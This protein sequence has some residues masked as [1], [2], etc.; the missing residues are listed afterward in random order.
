MS[1]FTPAQL[2]TLAAA[3]TDTAPKPP[4]PPRPISIWEITS[5]ILP[6]APEHFRR[7]LAADPS[8][9]QGVAGAEGGT[10][11]FAPADLGPL[12]AHFATGPRKARYQPAYAARA[13]LV[14]LTGPMGDMGRT[15]CLL[16]LATAA[17]LSG[18]RI[19]V[20]DGDPCG[21]LG[22][23][24][25]P[26][27]AFEDGPDNGGPDDRG[28]EAQG[29]GV[30]SLIALS[31][32]QHLRRLNEVRLDRGETPHPMDAVLTAALT[33]PAAALIRPSLWPGLDVMAAPPA[34]MQADLQLAGW[35]QSLRNW[36]PAAAL[37]MALDEGGLRQRYDL[38]LCDTPRGL[39]PLALSLLSA[40]DVLLA[41]LPEDGLPR[42]AEGLAA[43][44]S[45][46]SLAEA[47]ALQT[48]RALGQTPAPQLWQSLLVLPTRTGSTRLPAGF[49]AKLGDSLLPA[50]LPE[51]PGLGSNLGPDLA[52]F[53]DLDY[54]HI[55][56][57]AY[58]PLRSACDAAWATLAS[59]LQRA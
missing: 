6:M 18:Y 1:P 7:V 20:I 43:L 3:C 45:A 9:P 27:S 47:E 48:A 22:R 38:I 32:A 50:A 35:R 56:R 36:Q 55:G 44:G 46:T 11:W 8:L 42:L 15:T 40:A 39:G 53:Y 54:R 41:P 59:A 52:Q 17:A 14:A 19:L 49:A 57:L 21:R 13:P 4:S 2:T 25:P 30:L 37:A 33:L 51:I 24:L 58:A 10:R 23:T 28:T 31:A 29:A 16:H 12:R 5:W 26:P 34:L